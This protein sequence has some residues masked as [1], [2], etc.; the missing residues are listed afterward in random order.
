MD[1]YFTGAKNSIQNA[2][3]NYVLSTTI[4]ALVDNPQRTF[5][6]I[7]QAFFSRWWAEQTPAKQATVRSLVEAGQLVFAN[8]GY[9]MR[10]CTGMPDP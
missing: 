8:G 7:E 4:D 6:Y 10:E 9:C 3:V 2:G 1:Q 5:T